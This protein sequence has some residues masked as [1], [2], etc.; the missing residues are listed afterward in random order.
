MPNLGRR[1]GRKAERGQSVNREEN[2]IKSIKRAKKQIWRKTM[3][4]GLDYL[5]TL[6]YRENMQDSERVK[7]DLSLFCD[8]V[9][10]RIPGWKYLSVLQ[11][12]KRGAYHSHLAV[13][14]WQNVILLREIWHGVVG[15]NGGNIDAAAPKKRS[16]TYRWGR[17]AVARYISRYIGKDF[18]DD[19]LNKKRYFHSKTGL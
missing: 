5:L 6:T 7:H 12:Q 2:R 1:G 18:E 8:R 14:G 13:R 16:G 4:S 9:Q 11:R 19:E 10:Q 17:L 15:V 3:K